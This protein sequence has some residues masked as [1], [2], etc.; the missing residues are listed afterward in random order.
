M[1]VLIID[2]SATVRAVMK[3]QL[4]GLAFDEIAEAG[5][6][7]TAVEALRTGRFDVAIVDQKIDTGEHPVSHC[8]ETDPRLRELRTLLV[9]AGGVRAVPSRGAAKQDCIARPFT[10]QAL[11]EH[12]EALVA[13]TPLDGVA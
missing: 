13:G 8:I 3:T 7:E 6:A 5:D 10:A 9:A 1:R 2:E 11:R 12:V 4:R